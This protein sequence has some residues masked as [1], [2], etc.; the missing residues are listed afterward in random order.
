MCALLALWASSAAAIIPVSQYKY[1]FNNNGPLAGYTH[2]PEIQQACDAALQYSKTV[3]HPQFA[4]RTWNQVFCRLSGGTDGAQWSLDPSPGYNIG[5]SIV[6]TTPGVCPANSAAVSGGCQCNSGYQQNSAG[7]ACELP[8]PECQALAGQAAGM[9]SWEAGA[10]DG[11]PRAGSFSFCD[12]WNPK[13]GGKC[14]AKAEREF[15][16]VYDGR[17]ICQ[18]AAI[19]T[20]ATGTTCNGSGGDSTPGKDSTPPGT[21][22][23]DKPKEGEAAPSPCPKGQQPGTVNGTRVC[24]PTGEEDPKVTE[25]KK[26]VKNP[27]GSSSSTTDKNTCKG[28]KCTTE[29]TTCTKASSTATESCS[30]TTT[31]QGQAALCA[32]NKGS[33][34]CA[35][36]GDGNSTSFS[37]DCVAGFKA[38]SDDAVIAAMAQE[39]H[40][41]N[42]E[43]LSKVNTTSQA[44]DAEMAKTGNQTGDNPNNA[45]VS[46]SPS[47]IDMSDALGGGGCSLNKT[48]VVRGV[49]FALPFNVLCDP[50]AVFGQLLVAVSLLLAARIVT[51][52]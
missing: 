19:Y 30:T 2:Y 40:K 45:T 43:L 23:P 14:V 13:G 15:C 33:S 25:D 37:G 28:G 50:L 51:R 10:S 1:H 39:Q 6:R 49:S 38:E 31:T 47:N 41:R 32:A 48:V 22:A 34:V 11:S 3:S 21:P 44:I 8:P 35:G 12:G 9:K 36:Q 26:E 46:I 24:A 52:G 20:G 29:S 5:Q 7:T 16:G 27:D 17:W 42:C 18:G 4:S